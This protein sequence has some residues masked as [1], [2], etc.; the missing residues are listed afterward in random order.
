MQ[1]FALMR[2]ASEKVQRVQIE[3]PIQTEVQKLFHEQGKDLLSCDPIEFDGRYSPE[4]DEVLKI[5]NFALP[6]Y[7]PVSA[8]SALAIPTFAPTDTNIASLYG[9]FVI[10]EIDGT[11]SICVQVFDRRQALTKQK[12]ALI[13]GHVGDG[14]H[15]L[16]E[17]G[18][19][20]D[21]RLAAVFQTGRLYFK[22]FAV[23]SRLLELRSY[24]HEATDEELTMF[25]EH[26]TIKTP[27]TFFQLV[28]SQRM[29]KQIALILDSKILEMVS[30]AT[31]A[32]RAA[33]FKLKI[34]TTLDKGKKKLV[35]PDDRAMLKDTLDFL[36]EN[37]YRGI[38]TKTTYVSNSKRKKKT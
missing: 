21:T 37:F 32:K 7:F 12:F 26:E 9:L 38:L 31:I 1:L 4:T 14:F 20:L 36:E 29:R 18:L 6:A 15:K 30:P 25:A 11:P 27:S 28:D 8:S 17:T 5:S 23:A 10:S 13:W 33:S 24:Y 19:I 35:L 34:S 3:Q 16:Q 22:S 2:N